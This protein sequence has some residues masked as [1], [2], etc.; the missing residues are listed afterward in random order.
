MTQIAHHGITKLEID[1][2]GLQLTQSHFH[3]QPWPS[4]CISHTADLSMHEQVSSLAFQLRWIYSREIIVVQE[5]RGSPK[6]VEEITG[7]ITKRSRGQT[8]HATHL[9]FGAWTRMEGHGLMGSVGIYQGLHAIYASPRQSIS[10]HDSS[11]KW[12]PSESSGCPMKSK[13]TVT[14]FRWFPHMSTAIQWQASILI[15]GSPS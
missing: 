6:G 9:L 10:V 7:A 8:L 5:V 13:V 4:M 1:F 15:Q 12:D 11:F 14:H 2:C 3:Q